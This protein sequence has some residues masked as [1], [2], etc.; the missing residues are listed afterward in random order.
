M[1]FPLNV[2][3]TVTTICLYKH[4]YSLEY[5][6]HFTNSEK[7]MSTSGEFVIFHH[8]QNLMFY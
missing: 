3:K 2:D 6:I 4:V 1:F 5:V 7:I 8:S